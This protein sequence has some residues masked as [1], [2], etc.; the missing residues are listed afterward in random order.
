MNQ[1][2]AQLTTRSANIHQRGWSWRSR[3]FDIAVIAA[4]AVISFVVFW[5][6]GGLSPPVLDLTSDAANIATMAAA[7]DFPDNFALDSQF[8]DFTQGFYIAVHVPA[9]RLLYR[10]TQDYGQAFTLLLL[11]TLFAYLVA[12]YVLG[13]SL[14]GSRWY[15]LILA[16]VNMLLVKGPRDTAWGPFKDALPRFDHAVLFAVV[17]AILWRWRNN[18]WSWPVVFFLA[19]LG[20]Y[21][22]PVSTP[23]LGLMLAGACIGLAV[24]QGSIG[25]QV[26]PTL[27][28]LIAFCAPVLT[29]GLA[30]TRDQIS[31]EDISSVSSEEAREIANIIETRMTGHYLSPS[32]TVLEY[33]SRKHM[34]CGIL[35]C[36]AA[37]ILVLHLWRDERTWAITG[38]CVGLIF[39]LIVA[40][41]VIPVMFEVLTPPWKAMA[42][43]GELPRPLR[44]IVPITYVVALGAFVTAWRRLSSWSR[45]ILIGLLGIIGAFWIAAL[46]PR[47]IRALD[48]V[49]GQATQK[50]SQV[51]ELIN[52]IRH[53]CGP[54]Q[55]ICA[56]IEDPLIIRYGA[57]RSLA[58][59][60]KDQPNQSS[61]IEARRWLDDVTKFNKIKRAQ[62]YSSRV[63]EAM[64]WA[65]EK[66]AEYVIL[67]NDASI[68]TVSGSESKGWGKILF[69]NSRFVLIKVRHDLPHS[70]Q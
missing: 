65:Q 61:L 51:V 58:F 16:M 63:K 7:L 57:I 35:P 1:K 4:F 55:R 48:N 18:P 10:L 22:H 21:V 29:Y 6:R 41:V 59:A 70:V 26:L 45:H 60:P 20:L 46:A 69:Q 28:G 53:N 31:F 13:I 34:L 24:Y 23:A 9:T 33:F 11:P 42:F 19:G 67:E 56:I 40:T 36:L 27:V 30:F 43:K 8:R 32:R 14:F 52:A 54:Q 44:Y 3:W 66:G 25:K 62:D 5:A 47:A 68:K 37:G 15:G 50:K 64:R 49:T 39:G 17:L 12:F 38:M 2:R